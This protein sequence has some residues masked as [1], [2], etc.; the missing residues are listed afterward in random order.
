[1]PSCH[2]Q[3]LV[4]CS[5][6]EQF[7]RLT[8]FKGDV[9]SLAPISSELSSDFGCSDTGRRMSLANTTGQYLRMTSA[10]VGEP[11]DQPVPLADVT[12]R[13]HGLR[14]LLK[15]PVHLDTTRRHG[16]EAVTQ[17]DPQAEEI[18]R[19]A[20]LPAG[21]RPARSV[22]DFVGD[23]AEE[24]SAVGGGGADR[25]RASHRDRGSA[26]AEGRGGRDR[27]RQVWYTVRRRHC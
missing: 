12:G 6:V 4:D 20:G 16:M 10:V 2:R 24:V 23:G 11:S 8:D 13:M 14:W 25:V 18:V 22:I 5:S 26:Q 15:R 7:E 17:A 1:M 3:S 9:R 19:I 21:A 27:A